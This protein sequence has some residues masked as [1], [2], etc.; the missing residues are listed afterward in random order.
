MEPSKSKQRRAKFF[1]SVG[2]IIGFFICLT[3]PLFIL[4]IVLEIPLD[5]PLGQKGVWVL[6]T[7][8]AIGIS[9]AYLIFSKLLKK[10]GKF[11]DEEIQ[12]MWYGR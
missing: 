5:E 11:S 8:G 4:H 7:G 6:I 12:K 1:A 10:I 3:G 2:A 9:V